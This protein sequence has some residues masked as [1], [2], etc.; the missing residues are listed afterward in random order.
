[1]KQHKRKLLVLFIFGCFIFLLSRCMNNIES[2]KDPRGKMYA[3]ATTCVQC[4]K[5]ISDSFRETAHSLATA[6]AS[7]KY[8]LGTF[9]NGKNTFRFDSARKVVVEK[10]GSAFYQVLYENEIEKAA[11]HI[12]IIFGAR[13]AQ[14][15]VYWNKDQ[16]F[17]LP[18][19]WYTA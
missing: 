7:H 6:P 11:F 17:E 2:S 5:E 8:F 12:D 14:T 13:N 15:F 18:V 10:R 3:G 19:S 9:E 1:M 4:H 16:T